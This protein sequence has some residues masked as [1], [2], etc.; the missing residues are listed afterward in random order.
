MIVDVAQY[1]PNTSFSK[2][3]ISKKKKGGGGRI[4]P[5]RLT[6][7]T[8]PKSKLN[9]ENSTK[10]TLKFLRA[11]SRCSSAG[12]GG[13]FWKESV[14][15]SWL[16]GRA[17]AAVLRGRG[18][19]R[20]LSCRAGARGGERARPCA[21]GGEPAQLPG[22]PGQAGTR[23][24][25]GPAP[26]GDWWLWVCWASDWRCWASGSWRSGRCCGGPG[27]AGPQ[28]GMAQLL[29]GTPAIEFGLLWGTARMEELWTATGVPFSRPKPRPSQPRHFVKSF[30][31]FASGEVLLPR[32]TRE[33][34]ANFPRANSVL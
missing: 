8:E 2:P 26:W 31:G 28:A 32:Q 20:S 19:G 11:L 24:R 25:A 21:R 33:S 22:Q 1:L 18:A 12:F 16:A 15:F 29:V 23:R 6:K 10:V 30:P 4:P 3:K 5:K 14:Q 17:C 13:V 27:V 7:A 34:F 9:P